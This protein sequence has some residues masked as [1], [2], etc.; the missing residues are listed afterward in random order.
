MTEETQPAKRRPGRPRKVVE[1][2]AEPVAEHVEHAEP[3]VLPAPKAALPGDDRIGQRVDDPRWTGIT[4]ED[5]REYRVE[6][7]VIVE[8][9][10]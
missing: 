4:F 6:N 7:G 10:R 8:R 1:P 5:N 2:A 9:V 3:A